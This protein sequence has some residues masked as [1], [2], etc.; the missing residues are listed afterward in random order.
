M[1]D[2]RCC[3]ALD[4]LAC[5]PD[6]ASLRSSFISSWQ[7]LTLMS[8][9]LQREI[10]GPVGPLEALLDEPAGAPRAACVLAHPH[11]LHGGT[12]QAKAVYHASKALAGIGVASLRFNFRGVGRSGGTH[13][14]GSGEMKD[15]D[16]ALRYVADR[17][18]G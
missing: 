13:S 7:E 17:Y 3:P 5:A 16:A 6:P 4:I 14:G 11:P 1:P 9:V 2:T 18:P 10:P 15:Y 8:V 12:M